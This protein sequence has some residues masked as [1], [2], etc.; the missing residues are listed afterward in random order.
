MSRFEYAG[1]GRCFEYAGR[2]MFAEPEDSD[3][4]VVHGTYEVAPGWRDVHGWF[5][6][7]GLVWDFQSHGI[8]GSRARFK[9]TKTTPPGIPRDD[10]YAARRI[11][12][13]RSFTREETARTM[14]AHNHWGPW[15]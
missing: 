14:L 15:A 6:K 9:V 10:F 13:H 11:E 5:E 1:P 3:A 8:A 4:R 7:D 2:R 12:A